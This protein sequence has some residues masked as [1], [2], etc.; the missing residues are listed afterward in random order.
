MSDLI[1]RIRDRAD[2]QVDAVATA[3]QNRQFLR[4]EPECDDV[5]CSAI[6]MNGEKAMRHIADPLQARIL[7]DAEALK[8]AD[9]MERLLKLYRTTTPLGHE[10]H[11]I[12]GEVDAA[13]TAYLKARGC[14]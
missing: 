9:E 7:A 8:A 12:A 2:W 5:A 10:P 13:I 6:Y 4:G 14:E 1:E 11:M 3:T